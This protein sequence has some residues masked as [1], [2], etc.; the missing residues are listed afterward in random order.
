MRAC[1]FV[2]YS[3]SE[4]VFRCG[5]MPHSLLRSGDADAGPRKIVHRTIYLAPQ[6]VLYAYGCV[7]LASFPGLSLSIMHH[8]S[9]ITHRLITHTAPIYSTSLCY[10]M[11]CLATDIFDCKKYATF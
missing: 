7:G 6:A 11:T 10:D 9:C 8:A 5:A 3:F 4:G 2:E 1:A